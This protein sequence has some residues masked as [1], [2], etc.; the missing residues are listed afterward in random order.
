MNCFKGAIVKEAD[1]LVFKN[2]NV[3]I[4]IIDEWNSELESFTDKQMVFGIRPEDLGSEEAEN[5]PNSPKITAKI[6]VV[7]PMGSETYLYLAIGDHSFIA[8]VDSH[9]QVHVGDDIEL[10][11]SM[12]KAHVFD[13]ATENIVV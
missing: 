10:A 13:G 9:R 5:N 7:E 11:V 3:T 6:E 12:K 1:N 8:R 4:P 2:E